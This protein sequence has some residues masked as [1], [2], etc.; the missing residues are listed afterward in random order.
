MS[1]YLLIGLALTLLMT[2]VLSACRAEVGISILPPEPDNGSGSST[3]VTPTLVL[4][5]VLAAIVVVAVAGLR[6]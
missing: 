2:G 5:V 6:L 1:R 3:D 4:A